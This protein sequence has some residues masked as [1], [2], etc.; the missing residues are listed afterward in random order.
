MITNALWIRRWA[1]SLF[2]VLQDRSVDVL[3]DMDGGKLFGGLRARYS[4]LGLGK[5][6]NPLKQMKYAN[7]SA[8]SEAQRSLRK[9]G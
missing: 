7:N 6:K 9:G 2:D 4:L 8:Q 5:C 3:W 1:D